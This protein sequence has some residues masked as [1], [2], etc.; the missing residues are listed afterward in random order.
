MT[1]NQLIKTEK[2]RERY[3]T[4][5]AVSIIC[6]PVALDFFFFGTQIARLAR[7]IIFAAVS[8]FLLINHKLFL[9]SKVFGASTVLAV[10]CVYGIG[11]VSDL[12]LGGVITP[13]ILLLL[14]FL[15]M[16]ATNIDLY[17]TCLEATS[18][19]FHF[20]T[21]LS[22]FAIL[23]KL[24]PRGY[25]ASGEGYPVFLDFIGIPGR[26]Y[27]ILPHPNSLGQV[28]SISLILML[29]SKVNKI[30]WLIPT[31]CIVKCG[32]RTALIGL[33]LASLLFMTIWIFKRQKN[34]GKSF[35]LESPI[36]LG[37]LVLGILL[38]SS[39]Q[40]LSLIRLLDPTALTARAS[41]W[42]ASQKI[43]ESSP[44]FGVGW[45]WEIRAVEAQ[46]LNLWA[47]S[48]HNAIL[49]IAFSAGIVGLTIFLMLLAKFLVY[50]KFLTVR[51]KLIMCFLLTSGI[52]E[53]FVDLQYPTAQT[54]A[55]FLIILGANRRVSKNND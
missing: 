2:L 24:N 23:L 19:S 43:F 17:E 4:W 33:A 5:W 48:A 40:F 31:L 52:S 55:F 18:K 44:I 25:Y 8:A 45:G 37:V 7:I 42:Q 10:G 38:A 21:A 50:F 1:I 34:K 12:S 16:T 14:L 22:A 20:L 15:V 39:A 35:V 46:L 6:V 29:V 28:A 51:E 47:T 11:T 32:S 30:F 26:N 53:A 13:N 54:Y 41:I 27:G 9:N 3:V 36:A 49:D